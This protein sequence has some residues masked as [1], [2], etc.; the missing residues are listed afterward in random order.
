MPNGSKT[1]LYIYLAPQILAKKNNSSV[2][3]ARKKM[4]EQT[5]I[6]IEK[7]NIDVTQSTTD[8]WTVISESTE[9]K[10]K[11]YDYLQKKALKIIITNPFTSIQYVF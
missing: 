2:E 5:K 11:Y 4:K 10:K 7:N 6:W 1:A 9:V 8:F 3:Q